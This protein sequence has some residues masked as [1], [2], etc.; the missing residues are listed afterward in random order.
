M[1]IETR[2][3]NIGSTVS[4]RAVPRGS[5]YRYVN[6]NGYEY[7]SF[8]T[9]DNQ[10]YIGG[11]THSGRPNILALTCTPDSSPTVERDCEILGIFQFRIELF[12]TPEI[13]A[14][15]A[16]VDEHSFGTV[17]SIPKHVNDEGHPH[18]YVMMGN[19]PRTEIPHHLLLR[20][21]KPSNALSYGG[22][23]FNTVAQETLVAIRGRA[24]ITIKRGDDHA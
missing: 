9:V 20:V 10:Y 16:E 21:T 15:N 3:E 4:R 24:Y 13:R 12:D 2:V 22:Y 6:G 23:A 5:V 11:K 19:S 1:F 7:V 14:L 18:M 17:I 8:G